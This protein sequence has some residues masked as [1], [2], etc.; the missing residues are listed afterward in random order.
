MTTATAAIALLPLSVELDRAQRS[1]VGCQP[2]GDSAQ[3]LMLSRDDA[4]MHWVTRSP[5]S[6]AV[7]LFM[8]CSSR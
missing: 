3:T 4:A 2:S 1:R 7:P 8:S 6:I 5:D